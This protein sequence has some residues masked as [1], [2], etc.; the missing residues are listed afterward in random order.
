MSLYIPIQISTF[1]FLAYVLRRRIQSCMVIRCFNFLK[2]CLLFSI[3]AAPFYVPISSA[4]EFQ[5]LYIHSL[6]CSFLYFLKNK[7]CFN[8]YMFCFIFLVTLCGWWDLSSPAR[9]WTRVVRTQSLNHWTT[10]E[11][12][13]FGVLMTATLMVWGGSLALSLDC[14]GW[15][16]FSEKGCGDTYSS[17]PRDRPPYC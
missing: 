14:L 16:R 2:N 7:V 17:T 3:V 4:Q 8:I 11:V 10:R 9:D 6:S 15:V 13:P 1:T 12:P 5:L